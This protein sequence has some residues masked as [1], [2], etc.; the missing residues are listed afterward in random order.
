MKKEQNKKMVLRVA[1]FLLIIAVAATAAAV[2]VVS[3]NDD[4]RPFG[5]DFA[6]R[7]TVYTPRETKGKTETT[8]HWHGDTPETTDEPGETTAVLAGIKDGA[9]H[10]RI[11]MPK[12]A[13]RAGEVPTFTL[14]F[15]LSDQSYGSGR[16]VLHIVC[17]DM[18]L[19]DKLVITDYVYD[20]HA[21]NG[22]N[23]PDSAEFS[24]VRTDPDKSFAY[25]RMYL[26][27]EFIPDAGNTAFGDEWADTY[28]DDYDPDE[29]EPGDEDDLWGDL[30][31][32]HGLWVGGY[33][34]AYAITPSGVRFARRD[35]AADDFF[36]D[37]AVGQY[38]KGELTDAE[39]CDAYWNYALSGGAYIN[40]TS[41]ILSGETTLTYISPNL[42]AVTCRAVSDADILKMV[43]ENG[44]YYDEPNED[45]TVERAA[46]RNLAL[47]ILAELRDEGVIT[48]TEYDAEV[49]YATL[50]QN[51]VT[52]PPKID[53][54]FARYGKLIKE[55]YKTHE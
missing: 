43:A 33:A 12:T 51:Y 52:A 20:L 55:N 50:A 10:C 7:G 3:A 23:M 38:K 22:K 54:G 35:I 11:E 30:F 24:L 21:I 25:G 27:F 13:W 18:E 37:T 44:P 41:P 4:S 29:A 45:A 46:G 6:V 53:R 8:A 31:V 5:A 16:L 1:A 9:F 49:E 28:Y 34:C 14:N 26:Y 17:D 47:A 42:R 39:L 36:A 19:S 2:L 48:D 40:A 32:R 15:G